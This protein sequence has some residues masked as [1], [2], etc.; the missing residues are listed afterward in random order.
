MNSINNKKR[1]FKTFQVLH[2][3]IMQLNNC[4]N[5]IKHCLIKIMKIVTKI[6]INRERLFDEYT[7]F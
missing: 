3:I 2:T 1:I 6:V 4:I 7:K 5:I